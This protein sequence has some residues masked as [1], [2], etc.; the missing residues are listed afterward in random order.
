MKQFGTR[1]ALLD[2]DRMPLFLRFLIVSDSTTGKFVMY[3]AGK[4]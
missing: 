4:Y 3:A 2:A 1:P